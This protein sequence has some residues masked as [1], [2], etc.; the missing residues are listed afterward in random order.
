MN[1]IILIG[2]AT[3]FMMSCNQSTQNKKEITMEQQMTGMV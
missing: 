3:A 2:L 1:R